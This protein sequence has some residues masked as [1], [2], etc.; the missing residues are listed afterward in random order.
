MSC[1]SSPYNPATALPGTS[2]DACTGSGCEGNTPSQC[3]LNI[4]LEAHPRLDGESLFCY[5]L[6]LFELVFAEVTAEVVVAAAAPSDPEE[7]WLWF[8]TVARQLKVYNELGVWEPANGIGSA[9]VAAVNASAPLA[10]SGGA[11]PTIS[12]VSP[13]PLTLGGTAATDA[14]AARTNLGLG[15]IATQAANSVAIT[16]GSVTGIVDLAVADGGTGASTAPAARTNLGLGSIAT[17]AANSVAISGGAIDGTTLGA[18]VRASARVTTL[19]ASGD[20]VTAAQVIGQSLATGSTSP[21]LLSARFAEVVNVKD[22][23]AVGNGTTDDTAAVAAAV[24]SSA[25]GGPI[26]GLKLRAPISGYAV[27]NPTP[28]VAWAARP[29]VAAVGG[30]GTGFAAVGNIDPAGYLVGFEITNPGSGYD[31]LAVLVNRASGSPTI[32]RVDGGV[33]DARLVA[34]VSVR[35]ES[36]NNG[37]T[38]LSRSLD[39]LTLTL[40]ANNTFTNGDTFVFGL[41]WFAVAGTPQHD[42]IFPLIGAR[43]TLFF[44]PGTYNVTSLGVLAGLSNLHVAAEGAVFRVSSLSLGVWMRFCSGVDWTGGRFVF[45][46]A[47]FENPS[48]RQRYAG[49]SGVIVSC[50]GFVTFRGTELW[51]SLDFGF[52]IGGGQST[53]GV[54]ATEVNFIDVT[55]GNAL[56]DGIHYT[57]GA[58]QSRVSGARIIHPRDDALAVVDDSNVPA[59]APNNI[60]FD[61][62]TIEGG[63]YRGCVAIGS[64]DVTFGNIRGIGTHGPFCWAAADGSHASPTRTSFVNVTGLE[65]GNTAFSASDS[66]SGVGIF[67]AT[68]VGLYLRDLVFTQHASIVALGN[69]VYAVSEGTVTTF[70]Y[71]GQFAESTG[72]TTTLTGVANADLN[73]A[74]GNGFASVALPRGRWLVQGTIAVR[75]DGTALSGTFYP[76]FTDGS[77]EYGRGA[78]QQVAQD[79][80]TRHQLSCNAVI[81]T[82][83]AIANVYFRVKN[84]GNN[85]VLDAGSTFGPNSHIVATRLA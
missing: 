52:S 10:S 29:A 77:T 55:V 61:G 41:P 62:C 13:V 65:L 57:T 5:Y 70:D 36:L 50:S 9:I 15:S 35:H 58:R 37:V 24:A 44:P 69:S 22:F 23:G 38:I 46:A 25:A 80:G 14:P 40:S 2:F 72:G 66:S 31:V 82:N 48:T 42:D 60:V 51:D 27:P 75:S 73:C 19:D 32:T 56:G 59:K 79:G 33:F 30:L 85:L 18:S 78:T 7:G 53:M 67:A 1:G 63:I 68:T 54:W 71:D 84:G 43:K 81:T 34:G 45:T 83:S 76:T 12:L 20:V 74:A 3:N 11:T 47:K 4:G 28:A 8:D 26:V 64:T 17:Q 21:R 39:G 6:R 16:G 49:Q